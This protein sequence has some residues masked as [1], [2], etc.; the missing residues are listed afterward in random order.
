MLF[1]HPSVVFQPPLDWYCLLGGAY[2]WKW[3]MLRSMY[4]IHTIVFRE[5]ERMEMTKWHP[6]V[7]EYLKGLNPPKPFSSHDTL[8]ARRTITNRSRF[9]ACQNKPVLYGDVN[10]LYP[11]FNCSFPYPVRHPIIY[12]GFHKPQNDF[13][14][15]RSIIYPPHWL[16]KHLR[17]VK[18]FSPIAPPTFSVRDCFKS[19]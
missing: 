14:L 16:F 18:T 9:T 11:Y 3:Q 8:F 10:S 17:N 1:S 7:K 19:F 4:A 12:K 15:I 13:S 6:R 2:A 5:D